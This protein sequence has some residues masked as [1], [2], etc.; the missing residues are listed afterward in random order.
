M[1]L[2]SRR[3]DDGRPAPDPTYKTILVPVV[4]GVPEEMVAT[5]GHLATRKGAMIDAITVLEVPIELPLDAA[6]PD[7]EAK[8]LSHL[9]RVQSIAESY[10]ARVV[11]YIVRG[12][13]AGRAIVEEAQRTGAN[14]IMLQV[15][16][17]RRVSG[18]ALGPTVEYVIANAPCRVLLSI[19]PC[20]RP[21]RA[22]AQDLLGEPQA[23]PEPIEA[24][25]AASAPQSS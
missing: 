2:F 20:Q 6:L 3:G 19:E 17:K 8:I 4:P 21:G 22:P 23:P 10:G 12:R 9:E 11:T 14:V 1:K 16:A 15:P 25:P 18:P 5:A 7:K 24:P 13:K